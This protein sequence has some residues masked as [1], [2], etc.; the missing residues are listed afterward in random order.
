MSISQINKVDLVTQS[1]TGEYFLIIVADEPW[2]DNDDFKY[3]LQEKLNNYCSYFLDGQMLQEYPDS[4]QQRITV[5]ISST[6]TI[7][8]RLLEFI[9]NLSKATKSSGIDIETAYDKG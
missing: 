3:Q 6:T 9:S 2:I 7:P 8:K 1:R 5:R 4:K